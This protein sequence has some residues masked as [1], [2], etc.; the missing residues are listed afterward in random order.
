MDDKDDHNK[1][2]D[3][4]EKEQLDIDAKNNN[5]EQGDKDDKNPLGHRI[6]EYAG[7]AG[8]MNIAHVHAQNALDF[9]TYQA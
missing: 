3:M 8:W 9:N 7:L 6:L 4:D 2:G 5:K 1:Q